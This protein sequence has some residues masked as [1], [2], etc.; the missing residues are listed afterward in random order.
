MSET[1][2]NE[3]KKGMDFHLEGYNLECKNRINRSG[4]GVALF[5]DVNINYTIQESMSK[6]VDNIMECVTIRISGLKG[7][8]TYVCCV[9]R[10]PNS[11]IEIF[12]NYLGEIT[13]EM[14]QGN[15]F[16]CGDF[17]SII[18]KKTL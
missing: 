1:W 15:A 9:Y 3:H 5:I 6:V 14:K 12:G 11:N 16:V 2:I 7:K 4:G 8:K 17:S 18:F 13:A 10:A